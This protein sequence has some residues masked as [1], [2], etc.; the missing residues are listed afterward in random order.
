MRHCASLVYHTMARKGSSNGLPLFGVIVCIVY[1]H[2]F[3]CPYTKVEESFNLQAIHDIL[4]HRFNFEKYDHNEFPGVVPRTFLGPLF[5]SVLSAPITCVLTFLQA[6]KLYSQIL[7]RG[8]LGLCVIMALWQMQKEVRRQFGSMVASL[9]CFISTTQFHLMFYSTRTLPNVF[10]LP[11]VL[12]AF[13]SWMAKRH[14]PFI[15]LSALVIIVFRFELCLFLGLMLL[16]SLLSRKLN[17]LLLL[18]HGI[19]AGMLF[20]GLTVTIDTIFWNKLLW[21]EGKVLWYNTILNKSSNWGTSP[22]LWYF[23]SALPRALGSTILF[24]P[25]GLLDRRTRTLFIPA[26]GFILLYSILPH[27]ELRF[28]IYTFPVFNIIA[29]RGCSYILNSCHKSRIHK[30]CSVVVIGHLM[31]N[32]VYTSISLYVSYYNYPGGKAMQELHRLKPATADVSLHIDVLAAQ[33]GVSRFLEL[34][35]NWRYNKRE[36]LTLEDP[37]MKTYSH[38]LMEANETKI[39]LLKDSYK[40]LVFIPGYESLE[41]ELSHFPPLHI[42][43]IKK[44]MVLE[45]LDTLNNPN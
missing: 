6:P 33:T 23:Y 3:T 32:G 42:N 21:P 12:L 38:L 30:I 39:L 16:I 40:P 15:W 29:A 5:I 8:V 17:F 36:Y 2:L 19:P 37:I 20:L 41:F 14:C 45:R 18:Y 13:T 34:N 11:I 44:L 27:K 7:V 4:Y 35:S 9:F 10:A 31:L 24:I 25:V 43:L 1:V 22:F 28:I 26:V